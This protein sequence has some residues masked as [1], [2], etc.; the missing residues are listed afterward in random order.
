MFVDDL[1]LVNVGP[2]DLKNGFKQRR[3]VLTGEILRN[4]R[5]KIEYIKFYFGEKEYGVHRRRSIIKIS[6]D[7]VGEIQRYKC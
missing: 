5:G 7:K 2:E 3:K 1:L 4:S 6:D